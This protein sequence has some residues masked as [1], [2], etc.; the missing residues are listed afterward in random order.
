M[1]DTNGKIVTREYAG[2]DALNSDAKLPV[3]HT[4]K[5]TDDLAG[6]NGWDSA[7][8]ITSDAYALL[9][10]CNASSR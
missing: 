1:N 10:D 2:M 3:P 8:A 9:R 4:E 6:S 5:P 7:S